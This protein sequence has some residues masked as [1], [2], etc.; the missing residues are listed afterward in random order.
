MRIGYLNTFLCFHFNK[1]LSEG[2]MPT[3]KTVCDVMIAQNN[4]SNIFGRICHCT[5][6]HG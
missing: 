5:Q 3:M 2:I 6:K 1:D 4:A